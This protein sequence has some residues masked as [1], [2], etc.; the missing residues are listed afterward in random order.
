MDTKI[1]NADGRLN[2]I[3]PIYTHMGIDDAAGGEAERM[4]TSLEHAANSFMRSIYG[5]PATVE[6]RRFAVQ[7]YRS[8]YDAARQDNASGD[9]EPSNT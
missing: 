8:G 7:C 2:H 4:D 3:A 1:D 6:E 5:R 9:E